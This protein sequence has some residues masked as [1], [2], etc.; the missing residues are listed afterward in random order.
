MGPPFTP[1][2]TNMSPQTTSIN[3]AWSQHAGDVVDS[4]TISYS[5]ITRGCNGTVLG[6]DT[7]IGIDGHIR[8]YSLSNIEENS[9]FDIS[10]TAVNGAGSSPVPAKISSPTLVA[11]EIFMS[12]LIYTY[13][14]VISHTYTHTHTLTHT[15]PHTSCSTLWYCCISNDHCY[16]LHYSLHVLGACCVLR[17]EYRDHKA[18]SDI[19]SQ[20]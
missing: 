8:T 19:W 3:L 9:D 4:Y 11:G 6:E 5:Y 1:I 17:Q 16:H 2:I 12:T 20:L 18:C 15:H 13:C 14:V 10:I 7:I